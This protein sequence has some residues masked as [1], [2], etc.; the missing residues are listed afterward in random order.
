MP[1]TQKGGGVAE[2]KPAYFGV[3]HIYEPAFIVRLTNDIN[4][5]LNTK[6]FEIHELEKPQHKYNAACCLMSAGNN[7]GGVRYWDFVSFRIVPNTRST[8]R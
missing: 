5:L 2:C 8:L 4:M 1:A 3:S 6:G 7:L